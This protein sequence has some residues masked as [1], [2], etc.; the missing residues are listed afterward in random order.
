MNIK[1]YIII[2]VMVFCKMYATTHL[3]GTNSEY[4]TISDAAQISLPGD[5]IMIME[6]VYSGGIHL[7]KL[8]GYKAN[9]IFIISERN[10]DVVIKGGNNAIQFSDAK[11]LKIQGL[12]FERQTGNGVNIDDGGDYSTPT[13][14]IEISECIFRDM[15]ASGNNDLL[16]LSGLNDFIIDNCTFENGAEGGSGID[17]VGCHNGVIKNNSFRNM[18]SNAIQAKGGTQYITVFAN[19]FENCGQRTLNL[20]GSTGLQYFR[21]IDAPF[22]AADLNVYS[23][24]IIGS[25]A[26]ISYVGSVRVKVVNNTIIE[27]EKWV[28]RILQETVNEE[29]FA[30]CGNNTFENNLIYIGNLGTE[31]NIG[32]NTEPESFLINDNFWYNYENESWDGPD[33]PVTDM[34]LIIGLSPEFSNFAEKDFSLLK[35]SPAIGIIEY[36]DLPFID[37]NGKE[38]KNPRSAGAIEYYDLS[39]VINDNLNNINIYPNPADEFIVIELFNRGGFCNIENIEII[40]YMG[41]RLISCPDIER[42]NVIK[43]NISDLSKGVYIVKYLNSF[44]K[45]IVVR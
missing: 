5:T 27:P 13:E 6:G 16:K 3:V 41:E 35:K 10:K 24:I 31:T 12:I 39:S 28:I 8:Q 15:D 17:M 1:L 21:P 44:E 7:S 18:G 42:N 43:I 32:P 4:K 25:V 23:N 33:I 2:F 26:S 9:R 19:Y 30:K 34:N 14:F 29:R 22:E 45:F 37:F 38:F 11:Y 40:D 36:T 20:G